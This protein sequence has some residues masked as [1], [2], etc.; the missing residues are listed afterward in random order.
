MVP[1]LLFGNYGVINRAYSFLQAPS[2]PEGLGGVVDFYHLYLF[3]ILTKKNFFIFFYNNI[4]LFRKIRNLPY[5]KRT[6]S[7][8]LLIHNL[9]TDKRALDQQARRKNK[10]DTIFLDY[11]N[12]LIGRQKE[13]NSNNFYGPEPGGAN[14]KKALTLIRYVIENI[15]NWDMEEAVR[16]FDYYMIKL[17]KLERVALYIKRPDEIEYNDTRYILSLLYPQRVKMNPQQLIEDTYQKVIEGKEQFPRDY[18][19]GTNGFYRFCTCLQYLISNY[20]SFSSIDEIYRF[21]TAPAGKRFLFE[22]RLRVPASQLEIDI[23]DSIHVVTSNL[24]NADMY[25]AYYSFNEQLKALSRNKIGRP[26]KACN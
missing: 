21:F 16:K 25:Y 11:E 7:N 12:T 19:T 22:Y 20:K 2:K 26:Q 4:W 14:Q 15:L 13:L 5:C 6:K 10:M 24:E 9:N 3:H 23:L 17:M 18:F 1:V 8:S